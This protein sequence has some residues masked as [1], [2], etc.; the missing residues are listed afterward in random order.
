MPCLGRSAQLWILYHGSLDL[1]PSVWEVFLRRSLHISPWKFIDTSYRATQYLGTWYQSDCRNY[2]AT[3]VLERLGNGIHNSKPMWLPND[4]QHRLQHVLLVMGGELP[5]RMA[6][7]VR[8]DQPMVPVLRSVVQIARKLT[9]W[10]LRK[11][12][13]LK[14][15]ELPTVR[16]S[17]EQF[18][19][20]AWDLSALSTS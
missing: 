11:R 4:R 7:G 9:S 17:Y 6:R 5:E 2:Q 8:K 12:E 13:C 16:I 20:G 15:R 10:R 3:F 18:E 1:D 19:R 14:P